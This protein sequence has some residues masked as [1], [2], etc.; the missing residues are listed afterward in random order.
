MNSFENVNY[1]VRLKKQI[2]RKIIVE[3]LQ[4]L[5]AIVDIPNYHYLGFGSIYFSDFILFHK[6]LNINK[7]TSIDNKANYEKRFNYNKPYGFINF[8]VAHSTKYLENELNWSEKLFTWLDYDG[9]LANYIIEDAEIVASK[10]KPLDIFIVTIVSNPPHKDHIQNFIDEFELYIPSK[11]KKTDIKQHYPTVLNEIMKTSIEN[12]LKNQTKKIDFLQLFNFT[13]KD[14]TKMYTFGGIF[15]DNQ[16]DDIM[17]LLLKSQ[18]ISHDNNIID[19]NCPLLTTQEKIHLDS[20]INSEN[21]CD[22]KISEIGLNKEDIDKYC[23]YY[24]Y[25]PQYFE[26]LI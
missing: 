2:E 15:Y 9:S 18:C 21:E 6:Y 20:C 5:N 17:N 11:I 3:T 22:V 1:N 7:M 14:T 25:Y 13:Y 24:K 4:K 19:I 16:K 8:K 10:S 26:S 23:T 12:G